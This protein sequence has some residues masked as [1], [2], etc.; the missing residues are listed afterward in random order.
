MPLTTA[1]IKSKARDLGFNLC[2]LTPAQPSPTLRAYLRWIERGMHG[3]MG[4]M[5]R[6]DRVRRRQN[7]REIMPSAQSLIVVGL[8]YFARFA[9]EETLS[10]PAR[11]R[12]AAYAWGLDY[13]KV[14]EL[15]LE[16]FA[17]W[18]ANASGRAIQQKV[19]VDTGAILERSHAQGAGLGFI[20]KNTMLIHPRRGSSFF[21]GEIITSLDFDDYDEPHRETMCGTCTRCLE[22]CP[23]DAF[24]KPYVLDARRCISYHT[25]ENKGWIERELRP[26]FGNWIFGCDICMDVCPFQRFA[27]ETDE[28]AFLPFDI[29]RVAPPLTDILM[30]TEASYRSLFRRSP[31][32]R[33]KREQMARNACIAA[34]NW[35][36]ERVIPHLIQL[37]YDESALVRGHAAWALWRT[38]ELD[39]SKLLTDLHK[40]EDDERVRAE[41]EALLG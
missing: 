2:G 29:E 41:V 10:D 40:R 32:E 8:D 15:R 22:A 4:Y 19:Y 3:A 12:I 20:G 18:L 25:I 35:R 9:D 37:L 16:Q 11:G 21:I 28:V 33:I 5:A 38:M 24:P 31:V 39:S 7:L 26:G 36:G 14:L 27:T 34:G 23:T 1:A 17:E 6:L 30:S 13:H